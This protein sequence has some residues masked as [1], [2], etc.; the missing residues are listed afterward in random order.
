MG[1]GLLLLALSGIGLARPI[2]DVSYA[3]VSPLESGLRSL[4]QPI[5]DV[6]ANYGDVRDLTRENDKL[7]AENERLNAELVSLLEEATQ[8]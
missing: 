2:E 7:R 3:L 1:A 5:A 6:V 8:R 4:A